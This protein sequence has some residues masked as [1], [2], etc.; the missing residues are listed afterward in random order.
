MTKAMK[1]PCQSQQAALIHQK[2]TLL[3]NDVTTNASRGPVL[4][5]I[6]NALA[7]GSQVRNMGWYISKGQNYIYVIY[8]HK[9]PSVEQICKATANVMNIHYL[10]NCTS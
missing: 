6:M 5:T 3:Q 8:Q 9:A 10:Y 2:N 4:R 1:D 7:D